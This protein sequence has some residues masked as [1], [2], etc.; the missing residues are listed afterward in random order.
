M[1]LMMRPDT[2]TGPPTF[3]ATRGF[4][5]RRHV[6]VVGRSR[7]QGHASWTYRNPAHMTFDAAPA[8]RFAGAD[9]GH[10]VRY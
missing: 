2:S 9:N 10:Y 8:P 3:T 6:V 7:P 4:A 5:V 1:R